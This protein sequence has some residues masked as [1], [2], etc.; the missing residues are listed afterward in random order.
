MCLDQSGLEVHH[1]ELD[2]TRKGYKIFIEENGVLVSPYW[3][4][5]SS[6]EMGGTYSEPLPSGWIKEQSLLS[7]P[8]Y[9]RG[10]HCFDKYEDARDY[11]K[12]FLTTTRGEHVIVLV[13]CGGVVAEGTDQGYPSFVAQTIKLE[14]LP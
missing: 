1:E 3:N 5:V 6:Y 14:R 13:E 7:V 4:A 11:A 2:G 8:M 10:F 9:P 12:R